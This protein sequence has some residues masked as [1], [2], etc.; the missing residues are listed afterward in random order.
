MSTSYDE[1]NADAFEASFKAAVD[2][3]EARRKFAPFAE[4]IA[5]DAVQRSY[6][7]RLV[8]GGSFR[9]PV[10]LIPEVGEASEEQLAEADVLAQGEGLQWEALDLDISLQTIV[11]RALEDWSIR[12][13]DTIPTD[14]LPVVVDRLVKG[15][16]PR[17]VILFGS[18][19]RGDAGPDSDL[20]L[21][22]VMDE[23]ENKRET[24]VAMRRALADLPIAKDVIV[25]TPEEIARRGHVEGTVL[26]PALTEGVVLYD[27]S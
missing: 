24:T 18:F 11:S 14:F 13:D 8:S 3:G 12:W 25:T 1:P 19:A 10:S 7:V 26:K 16:Q 4:S 9:M 21:L 6:L 22:V 27:R 23:V 20:D 15:F 2:R 5:F 17:R